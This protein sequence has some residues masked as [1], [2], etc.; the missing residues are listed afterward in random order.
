MASKTVGTHDVSVGL[1]NYELG[2]TY[3]YSDGSWETVAD[4]S[5]QLVTW[6]DH[7]G[8][9]YHRFPDFTYRSAKWKTRKR[10]GNRQFVPR[11]DVLFKKKT[12][13]WPLKVGNVSGFSEMVTSNY[14]G[15]PPKSYRVNWTCEVIG[16]ER[17]AVMAGQ[18]DTWKIACKRYNNSKNPSKARV[19]ETRSWNYA[20]EIEHFV[21]TERQYSGRK[22]TRRLEL[23][24]V[25]PPL[26]SLPDVTRQQMNSAFQMALELKKSGETAAWSIPDTFWSGQVTP[27]D[28]FRLADGRYS[29]RYIQKLNYPD[30]QRIYH[31]LAVRDSKGVW[32]IPRR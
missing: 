7:R 25:L 12:S 27:T 5:P 20:P 23:L 10:Y 16:T 13:L 24:A 6:H 9:V 30:G 15:E 28:T 32:V 26:S 17:I 4:I 22:A 2:T 14:P 8:Y 18:F 1:P 19:K 31:G 11:S 21:M 29:R 3:V